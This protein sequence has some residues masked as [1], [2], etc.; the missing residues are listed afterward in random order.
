MFGLF[1]KKEEDKLP[2]LTDLNNHPLTAGDLV[3][4]L[5][6][7]LGKSKL[8]LV[9]N[10][11]YYESIKNGEQVSWLKMIDASSDRQKV[12]KIIIEE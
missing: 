3:E 12:K 7:D 5:R 4:V 1:K 9:D 6:Y 2:Q 10:N 11:Y 8:I